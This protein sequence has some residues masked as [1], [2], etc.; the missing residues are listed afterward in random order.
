MIEEF[1]TAVKSGLL[2]KNIKKIQDQN[3]ID[4]YAHLFSLMKGVKDL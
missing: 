4:K 2:F 1:K 3:Y